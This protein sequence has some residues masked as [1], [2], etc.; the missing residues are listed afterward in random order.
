MESVWNFS[1]EELVEF[2]SRY[3]S[4]SGIIEG[5][6]LMALQNA[7]LVRTE[8]KIYLGQTHNKLK[9]GKGR[10]RGTKASRFTRTDDCTRA[11][12]LR[13]RKT[14]KAAKYS[15]MET[16]ISENTTRTKNTAKALSSGLASVKQQVPNSNTQR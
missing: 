4:L 6:E 2:L 3:K 10:H 7:K 13:T 14:A 5:P 11:A 1:E 8:R 15:P 9:F 16:S 12:I